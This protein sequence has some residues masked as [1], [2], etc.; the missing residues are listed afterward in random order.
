LNNFSIIFLR[1]SGKDKP[2]TN[3]IS[4]LD[5]TKKG[6]SEGM[7]TSRHKYKAFLAARDVSLENKQSSRARKGKK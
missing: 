1:K 6:K 7:T 2:D 4:S 3:G 5:R